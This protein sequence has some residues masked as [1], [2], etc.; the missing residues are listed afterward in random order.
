[1]EIIPIG[2]DLAENLFQVRGLD[3]TGDVEVRK[4]LESAFAAFFREGDTLFGRC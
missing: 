3:A 1:M 2:L 4:T